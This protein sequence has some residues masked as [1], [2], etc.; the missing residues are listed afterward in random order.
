MKE[1][2]EKNKNCVML[3]EEIEKENKEMLK[4]LLKVMDNGEMKENKGKKI[5]FRNVI[6]IMKKNEGEQDMEKDDIGLGQ[7]RREGEE[8][9][10]IKRMFKKELRKSMD[11]IIKFGKMKVKVINKV[12]KKLVMKIEEKIE[13]RGVKFEMKDEEIEW[14]EEKGYEERMGESKIE[15][16]IKENIKKKME[17]EVILGKIKNG[18]KVSVDVKKKEDGNKEMMMERIEE[19]KVKKKKEIKKEKKLKKRRKDEK[20]KEEKEKVMD[21]KD[22]NEKKKK[23]K[24]KKIK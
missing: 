1:G 10:E 23:K 6:I 15:S 14:M 4:I 7:K 24:E 12:V 16:V 19:K 2:V 17:D 9:E 21:G 22:E 13:E 20:K 8:M 18:G 5:E 3:I 11:E